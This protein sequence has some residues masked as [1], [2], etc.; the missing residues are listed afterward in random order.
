MIITK[1]LK[2]IGDINKIN[3]TGDYIGEKAFLCSKCN[4]KKKKSEFHKSK[5][6]KNGIQWYCKQCK[7]K[8]NKNNYE[9][10]RGSWIYYIVLDGEIRWVGSTINIIN[11]ISKHKNCNKQSNFIY[12]AKKRNIDLKDKKI[13]IYACDV[14]AQGLNLTIVDLRYYEHK[15]IEK[16]KVDEDKLFNKRT[17]S[18][19]EKRDR[20]ID[21][22]PIEGFKFTLYKKF[23]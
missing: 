22:I 2:L 8:V 3:K 11:R 12:E 5:Y 4:I 15:L 23:A 13:E 7:S 20:Y 19:F 16:L 14:I 6:N 18:K 9:K 17:K 10:C 21:E 1:N